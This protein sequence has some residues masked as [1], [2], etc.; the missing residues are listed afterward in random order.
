MIVLKGKEKIIKKII[1]VNLEEVEV[2]I[3]NISEHIMTYVDNNLKFDKLIE[4]NP[5]CKHI[6]T[7]FPLYFLYMTYFLLN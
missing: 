3:P 4:E 5:K 1:N 7:E 6:K 2:I